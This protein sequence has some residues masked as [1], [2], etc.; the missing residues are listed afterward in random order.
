MDNETVLHRKT[1]ETQKSNLHLPSFG[2]KWD[3]KKKGSNMPLWRCRRIRFS[4]TFHSHKVFRFNIFSHIFDLLRHQFWHRSKVIQP[5]NHCTGSAFVQGTGGP[6]EQI[7][8]KVPDLGRTSYQNIFLNLK[9]VR[10]A[11]QLW[12]LN[13]YFVAQGTGASFKL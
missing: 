11:G 5:T 13:V 7:K 9:L 8:A 10:L 2:V 3:G 12:G 1:F 6:T 4:A